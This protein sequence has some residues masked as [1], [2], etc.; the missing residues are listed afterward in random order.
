MKSKEIDKSKMKRIK[1]VFILYK[2]GQYTPKE[3]AKIMD[4][5]YEVIKFWM[6][7]TYFY[8]LKNTPLKEQIEFNKRQSGFSNWISEILN[9]QMKVLQKVNELKQKETKFKKAS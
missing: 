3:I 6:G 5:P 8:E 1:Q 2:S 4:L 7:S 9:R